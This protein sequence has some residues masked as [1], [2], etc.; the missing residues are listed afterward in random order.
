[1]STLNIGAGSQQRCAWCTG[2][3]KWAVA[4]GY[5]ISC[6]VCGGKGQVLV[7]QPAVAC[8][9]CRGSGKRDATGPCL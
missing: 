9:Q 3:G 4:A 1:M 5:V 6:P 7:S 8:R 2:R